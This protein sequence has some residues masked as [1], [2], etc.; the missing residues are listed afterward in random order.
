MHID[1]PLLVLLHRPADLVYS[2][3]VL[4]SASG[5]DPEM[6]SAASGRFSPVS[7]LYWFWRRSRPRV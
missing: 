7:S 3:F 1:F 2:A 6:M 4:W 5:L